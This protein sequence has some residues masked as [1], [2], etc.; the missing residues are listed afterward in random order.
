MYYNHSE[1]NCFYALLFF[2]QLRH[3][4]SWYKPRSFGELSPFHICDLA[5]IL[6]Q[7]DEARKLYP[8]GIL[9]I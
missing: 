7:L 9:T 5:R 1:G 4:I 8:I 3:F 2:N 6:L